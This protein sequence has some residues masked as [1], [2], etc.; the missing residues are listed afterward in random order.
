MI[1]KKQLAVGIALVLCSAT[2]FSA[3]KVADGRGNA[4]GNTGVASADYLLAPFYNPALAGAYRENDDVGLLLPA[5]QATVNDNDDTLSDIEDLQDVVEDTPSDITAIDSYLDKLSD[6]APVSVNAG[7]GIAVAIPN[8]YVAAN[9]FAAGYAELAVDTN[10]DDDSTPLTRYNNSE[11]N[12]L[13]FT[14]TEVGIALAKP[15]T[16]AGQEITFGVSPKFQRLKTYAQNISLSDYDIDD[17]DECEQSKNSFN[18]DLGAFWQKDTWRVG[19]AVKNLFKRSLDVQDTTSSIDGTYELAPQATLGGAY[20]SR[21]FT[22]SVDLDL[23]RQTRFEDLNISGL[24][25][26]FDDTQFLRFGVEGNAWDWLQLRA[27]YEV[28]LLSNMDNSVT[29]GIGISPFDVVN[30]DLAGSYAGDNQYG[31]T[32]SLAFTF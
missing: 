24:D 32:L 4:M 17:Y 19:L 31:A 11:V 14:Y 6:N 23:T 3:P 27:G 7:A 9:L 15:Y 5:L 12:L 10:I 2:A 20:L 28:D 21:F 13:A 16:V 30:I 26:D 18:L 22:A 8:K 25:D 1:I 29:A